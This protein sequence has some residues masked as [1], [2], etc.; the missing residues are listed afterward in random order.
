MGT[1]AFSRRKQFLF[2]AGDYFLSCLFKETEMRERER[3]VD[4]LLVVVIKN[5]ILPLSRK[6]CIIVIIKQHR[7]PSY[8]QA[9]GGGRKREDKEHLF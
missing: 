7:F 2:S 3:E 8:C 6:H 5:L 9:R 4:S 1:V